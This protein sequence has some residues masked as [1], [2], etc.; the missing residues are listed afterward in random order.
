MTACRNNETIDSLLTAPSLTREQSSVLLAL[1]KAHSGNT[2]FVYPF[3]GKNRSAIRQV[4]IDN[5][6]DDE[7]VA[8]F[9][10]PDSGI[11]AHVAV[12]EPDDE[13]EYY[14]SSEIEGPGSSVASFSIIG[15]NRS[16]PVLLLEW[17]SPSL[18][19]NLITAY[20]YKEESLELG[21]EEN[22]SDIIL[23]D[24]DGDGTQE[25]CYT[26]G[27]SSEEGFI[28]KA[29][30]LD[31]SSFKTLASRRL[32][33]TVSGVKGLY[34]GVLHDGTKALFID[35]VTSTG[36][37]TEVVQYN[38]IGLTNAAYHEGYDIESLTQRPDSDYLLSRKLGGIT[39]IPSSVAPSAD[40][41]SSQN[42]IYWYS[43]DDGS[44]ILYRTSYVSTVYGF[45]LF[46][47]DEWAYD[48]TVQESTEDIFAAVILDKEGSELVSLLALNVSDDADTYIS[49]EYTLVGNSASSRFF[50]RF[51]CTDEEADYIK[52]N[53]TLLRLG[54]N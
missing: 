3:S 34:E 48:C 27:V 30:K 10:V 5:D 31:T 13:G 53:F 18:S 49:D 47:P 40:I 42:L 28:L 50:C 19:Y 36:L 38:D 20:S 6:G 8:L 39:C 37:Q 44:I 2:V 9:R 4:D 43:V 51:S 29:V 46:I 24:L 22:C 54:E 32:D 23:S 12:L 21:M 45:A 1:D 26:T 7:A 35:E 16:I 14:I 52:N 25:F 41:P 17:S 11:N 15:G 33:R